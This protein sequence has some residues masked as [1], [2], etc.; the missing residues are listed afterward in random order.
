MLDQIPPQQLKPLEVPLEKD[1][2]IFFHGLEGSN[3]LG[4]NNLHLLGGC[5]QEFVLLLQRLPLSVQLL[6][7]YPN[8]L[9]GDVEGIHGRDQILPQA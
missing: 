3:G 1:G 8:L 5:S 7:Q 9:L 2:V 4:H 6:R